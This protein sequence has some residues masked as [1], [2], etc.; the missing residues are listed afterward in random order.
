[1]RYNLSAIHLSARR[2][3]TL[4]SSHVENSTVTVRASRVDLA[5]PCFEQVLEAEDIACLG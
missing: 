5:V 2:H 4:N 3:W 1:M